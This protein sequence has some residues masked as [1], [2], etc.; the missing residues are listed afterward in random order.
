MGHRLETGATVATFGDWQPVAHESCPEISFSFPPAKSY[1]MGVHVY[2]IAHPKL[3]IY[4][5]RVKIYEFPFI[6]SSYKEGLFSEMKQFCSW[7]YAGVCYITWGLSPF[8][9]VNFNFT[10]SV[11]SCLPYLFI[12]F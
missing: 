4:P 5:S 8:C 3:P 2:V 10:L 9:C 11:N 12:I 7:C 6:L 1:E